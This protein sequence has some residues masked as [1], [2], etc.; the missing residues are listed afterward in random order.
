M[1]IQEWLSSEDSLQVSMGNIMKEKFDKYLGLWHTNNKD[2]EKGHQ[3]EQERDKGRNKCKGKEKEKENINLLILVAALLDPRY[4]L[5]LYTKISVEEIFGEESGK[6]VWEAINTSV[7]E[8]FEEYKTMYAPNEEF[9]QVV[10]VDKSKRVS[11]GM[12]KE[13]IAKKMKLN[14]CSTSTNK[15]KLEKYLSEETEDPES[16]I[17]ILAWWKVN[18]NRFPVLGHMARDVLAIPITTVASE[19]A[20]STGGRILDDFRTSLTPFMLEALVCTQ[21][22]LRRPTVVIEEST[23][24]LTIIG[25]GI[26]FSSLIVFVNQRNVI[27]NM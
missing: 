11:R 8:L 2:N 21:D 22:W 1:L 26:I 13:K 7:T 27:L 3:Q 16:K 25:K 17:D 15:S 19:S 18:S 5:S 20:F 10:D 14:I 9:V 24:E 4:K 23:E 12:L 6:L